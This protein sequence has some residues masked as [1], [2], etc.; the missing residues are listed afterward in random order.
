MEWISIE[1]RLPKDDGEYLVCL[2]GNVTVKEFNP[3]TSGNGSNSFE[4]FEWEKIPGYG[5]EKGQVLGVT[6][7]MPLPKPP[8]TKNPN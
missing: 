5:S 6:H 7:W 2:C 4:W 1:D 8:S 3:W